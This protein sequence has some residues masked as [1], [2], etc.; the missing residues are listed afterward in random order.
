[1]KIYS[2]GWHKSHCK[3]KQPYKRGGGK[4][5]AFG[6]TSAWT[7]T[8]VVP[9]LTQG[10]L[11]VRGTCRQLRAEQQ[12]SHTPWMVCWDV[13]ATTR[14]TRCSMMLC[15]VTGY[16]LSPDLLRATWVAWGKRRTQT[17]ASCYHQASF[18]SSGE[19]QS[20]LPR[21]AKTRKGEESRRSTLN[22][23]HLGCSEGWCSSSPFVLLQ[24][25]FC[26]FFALP[27]SFPGWTGRKPWFSECSK[28]A[29]K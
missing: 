24:G 16:S 11:L 25:H 20:T 3:C 12:L 10:E 8:G 1:M 21:E 4:P 27:S 23:A 14:P 19:A 2:S 28:S 7:D 26:V 6:E 18:P 22:C 13:H 29:Y 17:Q 9:Q 5:N 15:T